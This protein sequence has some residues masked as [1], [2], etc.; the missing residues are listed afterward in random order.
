MET[1]LPVSVKFHIHLTVLQS[2]TVFFFPQ[3]L[4]HVW[5]V[6]ILPIHVQTSTARCFYSKPFSKETI[7]SQHSQEF[8][9][10][11]VHTLKYAGQCVCLCMCAGETLY[12]IRIAFLWDSGGKSLWSVFKVFLKNFFWKFCH[13]NIVS[14]CVCWWPVPY[15]QI[16][17]YIQSP[18][19]VSKKFRNQIKM[20]YKAL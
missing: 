16:H 11:E 8:Q 14:S 13:G 6:E 9:K 7:R 3:L 20:K 4:V 18:A 1:F 2:L 17:T 15:V 5:K 10:M 12:T 19:G